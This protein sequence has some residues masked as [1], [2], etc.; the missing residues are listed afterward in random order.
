MEVRHRLAFEGE[1]TGPKLAFAAA[2][3]LP[4]VP[5]VLDPLTVVDDRDFLTSLHSR[6]NLPE[7]LAK[8]VAQLYR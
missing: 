1:E 7:G 6:L 8:E 3:R 2:G 4:L 5:L